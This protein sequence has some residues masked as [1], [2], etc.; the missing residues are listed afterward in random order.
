[1][2]SA[3]ACLSLQDARAV[4][5]KETDGAVEQVT[6]VSSD[7]YLTDTHARRSTLREI[8]YRV[9]PDLAPEIVGALLPCAV[10]PVSG[11]LG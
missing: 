2:C 11:I 6:Q 3:K 4:M 9:P 5:L 8:S 1:M 10:R 7:G